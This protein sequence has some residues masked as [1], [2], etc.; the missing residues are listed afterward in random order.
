MHCIFYTL[1]LD[2]LSWARFDI[3]IITG[4][5]VLVVPRLFL[6][7]FRQPLQSL[8]ICSADLFS[9]ADTPSTLILDYLS[10]ECALLDKN[11]FHQ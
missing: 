10:L 2:L 6:I 1:L 8:A 11:N 4:D 3:I 9:I 7:L 5:A